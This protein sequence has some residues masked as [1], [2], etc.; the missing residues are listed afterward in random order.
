MIICRRVPGGHRGAGGTSSSTWLCH[1]QLPCSATF[2]ES[3]LYYTRLRRTLSALTLRAQAV[4][5][6]YCSTFCSAG[7]FRDGLNYSLPVSL[8]WR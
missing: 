3:L 6:Q 1:L 5:G 8:C 2:V 4:R 7:K